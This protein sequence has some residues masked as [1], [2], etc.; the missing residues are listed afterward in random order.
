M[1]TVLGVDL[2]G[3]KILIGE[4]T[5]TGEVLS[6]KSYT[7]TVVSQKDATQCIKECLHDFLST[8]PLIGQVQAIGIGVVGR[9][10]RKRGIWIE[11]HPELSQQIDLAK[12]IESEFHWPCYIGNDVYCATLSEKIYGIGQETDDFI[13]LNIGTGIAARCVINGQIIEGKN[14]DAGEVGHMV[15]DMNSDVE[16][17][18]GNKGCVE[19]LASGLGLHNRVMELIEQYPHSC[20][21]KKESG[22]IG[23]IELF[24]GYDQNDELCKIVVDRALKAVAITIMNLIRV[25]DPDAIVL[26]GGVGSSYWFIEHLLMLMNAKTTRFITKGIQKTKQEAKTIGLKGAALL[27]ILEI[28]KAGEEH[29]A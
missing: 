13:Y 28:E 10:D 26:G 16:C 23:A 29:Y 8:I 12:E 24:E 25:S 27:A 4:L 22:R 1:R 3:T 7:S 11:I 6:Q 18:C 15:V 2:G 19:T 9:V 5:L 14:F 20:I 21:Q 17:V